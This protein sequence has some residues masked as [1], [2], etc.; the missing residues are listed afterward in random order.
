M[1]LTMEKLMVELYGKLYVYTL[2][3]MLYSM[4]LG[5]STFFGNS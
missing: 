4:V 1:S 5:V 3:Y 2:D